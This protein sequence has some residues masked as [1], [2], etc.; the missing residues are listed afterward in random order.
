MLVYGMFKY[1]QAKQRSIKSSGKVAGAT[2]D[3]SPDKPLVFA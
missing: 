2:D 3:W 1:R